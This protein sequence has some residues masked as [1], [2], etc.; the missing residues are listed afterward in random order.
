MSAIGQKRT[1]APYAAERQ[2][3][4]MEA[5]LHPMRKLNMMLI[6]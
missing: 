5:S 1:L 4:G 6:I 2:K 3:P